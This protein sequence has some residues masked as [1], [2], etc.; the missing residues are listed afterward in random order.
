M[1]IQELDIEVKVS[2]SIL[3]IFEWYSALIKHC[4][5]PLGIPII[6]G[7]SSLSTVFHGLKCQR[8][9]NLLLPPFCIQDYIGQVSFTFFRRKPVGSY[10][11]GVS[12]LFMWLPITP[13]F[14]RCLLHRSHWF[15]SL[16]LRCS[17]KP[18]KLLH[19]LNLISLCIDHGINSSSVALWME[20]RKMTD[21]F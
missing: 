9:L 10:Y 14:P 17:S 21:S 11:P 1:I 6:R 19:Y 3:N 5:L 20:N 16:G 18:K 8:N 4:K 12:L 7:S 15:N 2:V 13:L